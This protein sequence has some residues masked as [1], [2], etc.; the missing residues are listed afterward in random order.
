MRFAR[1]WEVPG[2][3]QG[4]NM[5][6]GLKGRSRGGL[7]QAQ[8]SPLPLCVFETSLTWMT[9]VRLE[10]ILFDELLSALEESATCRVD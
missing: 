10:M 7:C 3:A 1:G 4:V 5:P 9:Q 8:T 6:V 2:L